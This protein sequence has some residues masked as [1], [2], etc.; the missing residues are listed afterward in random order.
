MG[1]KPKHSRVKERVA[2]ATLIMSFVV[3]LHGFMS[4]VVELFNMAFNSSMLVEK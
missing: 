1:K 3:T 4:V 2:L